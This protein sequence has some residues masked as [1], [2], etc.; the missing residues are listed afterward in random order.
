M[1]RRQLRKTTEKDETELGHI[2][3]KPKKR[4]ISI[5]W[6]AQC[7]IPPVPPRRE[8]PASMAVAVTKHLQEVLF[9]FSVPV[10]S[11][12]FL[13]SLYQLVSF[14]NPYAGNCSGCRGEVG[15]R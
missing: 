2:A 5:A 4:S 13:T 1:L 15:R 11:S 3:P 14:G 7:A 9:P 6:H 8:V 12:S 10:V